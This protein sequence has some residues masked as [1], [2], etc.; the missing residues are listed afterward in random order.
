MVPFSFGILN[1]I[2]LAHINT[3][4]YLVY[5]NGTLQYYFGT[6]YGIPK[7]YPFPLVYQ[8][9]FGIL[10]NYLVYQNG[11]LQYNF[12]TPYGI[13]KWYL[14]PLVYQIIFGILFNYLVNHLVY[15]NGIPVNMYYYLVYHYIFGIPSGIPKWYN[16]T[17]W[18]SLVYQWYRYQT[19]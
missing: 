13:P 5:Q 2:W 3:I 8:I 18:Y 7:W 19:W 12:G 15:Q 16:F 14:F 1:N 9:I 4:I 17:I 11:T 10:F 6:P